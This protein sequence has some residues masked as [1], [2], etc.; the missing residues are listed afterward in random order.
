MRKNVPVLFSI[1]FFSLIF[2]TSHITLS[3]VY[4]HCYVHI[5]ENEHFD[6][7]AA[8][9]IVVGPMSTPDMES[10]PDCGSKTDWNDSIMS[11]SVGPRA[12]VI[13][14]SEENYEG[15]AMFLGPGCKIKNLESFQMNNK[16]GSMMIYDSNPYPNT[17]WIVGD[18]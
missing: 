15:P 16:I 9:L 2:F 10:L 4:T 17:Q 14:Y 7:G 18:L 8:H 5:Y 6:N 13:V 1:L 12:W 11:I 3:Q